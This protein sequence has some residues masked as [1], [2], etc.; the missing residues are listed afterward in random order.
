MSQVKD[1][2]K[3]KYQ[4][5]TAIA[6]VDNS[7]Q[8]AKTDAAAPAEISKEEIDPYIGISELK[9]SEKE[10]QLLLSDIADEEIEIRPDGLIYLPEIKYRLILNKVFGPG[11]WSIQPRGVHIVDN[12]LC[13]KGALYIR[14]HF[15]AEAIGEQKYFKN[16][17][18]QSYRKI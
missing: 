3:D 15:V 13:Y 16:N 6:P 2:Y 14:G 8:I 4:E 10:R 18:N 7:H 5:K 9:L 17:P 1:E 11:N 12:V